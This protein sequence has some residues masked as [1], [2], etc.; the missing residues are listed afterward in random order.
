MCPKGTN[1]NASDLI[2]EYL[3]KGTEMSG[4]HEKRLGHSDEPNDRPRARIPIRE[5]MRSV[6]GAYAC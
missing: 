3:P 1:K 6:H 5:A 4:A 2:Q